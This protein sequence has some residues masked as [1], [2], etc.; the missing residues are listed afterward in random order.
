M[1]DIKSNNLFQEYKN[2]SIEF[3]MSNVT[4]GT[5]HSTVKCWN[6]VLKIYQWPISLPQ[7]LDLEAKTWKG[8]I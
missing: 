6:F 5:M 1:C 2:I 3:V 8:D 4:K 7:D